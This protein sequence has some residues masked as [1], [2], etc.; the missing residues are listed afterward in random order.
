MAEPPPPVRDRCGAWGRSAGYR[1]LLLLLLLSGAMSSLPL[2]VLSL[3]AKDALGAS[4]VMITVYFVAVASTG[5]LV[6]LGSGRRSDRAGRRDRLV[7]LSFAW[8]VVGYLALSLVDSYP[9][10]VLVG[11]GFFPALGVANA[12][13]FALARDVVEHREDEQASIVVVSAFRISYSVGSFIGFG[14]GGIALAYLDAR[15]VFRLA[16]GIGL[17]CLLVSCSVRGPGRGPRRP[18]GGGP[19]RAAGGAGAGPPVAGEGCGRRLLLLFTAT[20]VL[21]ASGRVMQVSQLPLVLRDDLG[22]PV[23]AVGLV[24]A[25]PPLA[26]L[27]LMPLV[28][29]AALRVGRGLVFLAGAAASV[30]YYAGLATASA[31]P[32]LAALQLLYAFFGAAVLMVGIDLAQRLLAGQAGYATSWYFSHENWAVVSGSLVATASVQLAGRQA[33]FVV[34]SMLCAVALVSGA[35]LFLRHPASFDVVRRRPAAG[36]LLTRAGRRRRR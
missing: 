19:A 21:F 32:Q 13:L 33:G 35:V 34:P 17:A 29:W 8:L 24:L 1:P 12:Q 6:M 16:A 18:H 30:G 14:L 10:M 9:V 2:G 7:R 5:T 3:F 4:D 22:A 36:R 20:M 27:A 25:A 26:E 15:T 11:V 31:W 28:A 23:P